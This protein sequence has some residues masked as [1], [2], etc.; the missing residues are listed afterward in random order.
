LQ[1]RKKKKKNMTGFCLFVCL[2]W[3]E[4]SR[5][6]PCGIFMNLCYTPLSPL[7]IY[8]LP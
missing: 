3:R 7:I 1:K 5:E 8:I 4:L 6:F 2:R